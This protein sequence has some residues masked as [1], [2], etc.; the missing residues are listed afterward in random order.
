[1]TAC[2]E[3]WRKKLL[4]SVDVIISVWVAELIVMAT[5]KFRIYG[6]ASHITELERL[7]L[8][9]KIFDMLSTVGYED[10]WTVTRYTCH[11]SRDAALSLTS[12]PK[13]ASKP[14]RLA[15]LIGR[16]RSCDN[17]R[18]LYRMATP[19]RSLVTIT[20]LSSLQIGSLQYVLS[21]I[22]CTLRKKH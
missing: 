18:S 6:N 19:D 14:G 2:P 13:Q 4:R 8:T 11:S 9:S 17:P 22:M 7:Q 5:Q 1:M 3:Y 21:A 15:L 20:V 16:R 10:Y 12:V